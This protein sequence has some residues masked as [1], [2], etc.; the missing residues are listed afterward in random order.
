MNLGTAPVGQFQIGET[1]AGQTYDVVYDDAAF[2][3]ARLGP[4][5]D[6]AAPSVPAGVTAAATSPFSVRGRLDGVDRRLGGGRLRRVPRRRVVV[7]RSR[8]HDAFTDASV[9]AS[10]TYGYAVRARDASEQPVGAERGGAGDDAGGAR[11]GV[12]GRLRVGD[13]C[14][15][16]DQR[17]VCA[18]RAPTC[19]RAGSRPRATPRTAT[20]SRGRRWQRRTRTG[21]RGWRSS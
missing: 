5:A 15:V 11:A 13:L 6:S 19:A 9:L 2:G 16:D 3:S 14:G 7:R 4:V 17:R 1:Q 21:T 12:R 10:T 8:F 20:C 18:S